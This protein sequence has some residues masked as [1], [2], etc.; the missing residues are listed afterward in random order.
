VLNGRPARAPALAGAVVL[1]PQLTSYSGRQRVGP[2]WLNVG[3]AHRFLRLNVVL[4]GQDSGQP[5]RCHGAEVWLPKR[6][7]DSIGG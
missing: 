4:R 7:G 1:L 2:T 5:A 6:V 3:L